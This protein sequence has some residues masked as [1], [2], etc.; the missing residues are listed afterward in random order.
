MTFR[1]RHKEDLLFT[2]KTNLNKTSKKIQEIVNKN[3]HT[4]CQDTYISNGNVTTRNETISE[5]CNDVFVNIGPTRSLE[6]HFSSK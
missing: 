1:K 2:H 5:N 6:Q 3:K 4:S